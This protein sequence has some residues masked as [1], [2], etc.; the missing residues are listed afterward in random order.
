MRLTKAKTIIFS[1]LVSGFGLMYSCT[2]DQVLPTGPDISNL[3]TMSFSDDIKPIFNASC[4]TSG[5]HDGSVS[6]DLRPDNAFNALTAGNYL[7]TQMPEN[8]EL[9]QWMIGARALPMPLSGPNTEYNNKVLA[10]IT[11]GALNN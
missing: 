7:N 4:N 10:W 11:Q 9:Y 6:P 2:Y 8:S 5:C 1:L 3:G